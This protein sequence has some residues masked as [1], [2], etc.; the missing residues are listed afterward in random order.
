MRLGRPAF[1]LA[2][3]VIATAATGCKSGESPSASPSPS[4]SPADPSTRDVTLSGTRVL[5]IFL[6]GATESSPLVVGLHGRGGTPENFAQALYDYPGPIELALPQAPLPVGGGSAWFGAPT[7]GDDDRLTKALDAADQRLWPVITAV[8]QGRKVILTGFSQGGF[9]TY[10]LAARHPD[11][12]AYAFPI[13]GACPRGLFPHDHAKTAPIYALHGI[14]D[15]VVPI[16]DDRATIAA[17]KDDGAVAELHEFPGTRHQM[18]PPLRADLL[19][20][21]QTVAATLGH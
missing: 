2:C 18:P 4:S 19:A 14:E 3:A 1:A 12:V 16:D 15:D 10:V 7:Q 21:I 9:M 20:H 5:E 17:F 6:H 11:V 13:S 8:A